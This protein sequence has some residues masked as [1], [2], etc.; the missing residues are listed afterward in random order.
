MMT[1]GQDIMQVPKA[2]GVDI[3]GF[4]TDYLLMRKGKPDMG[5]CD[6]LEKGVGVELIF[7]I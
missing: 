2:V 4:T 3:G 1:I 7:G 5:Y 6:S